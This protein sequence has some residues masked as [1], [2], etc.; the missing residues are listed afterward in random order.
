MTRR[1]LATVSAVAI[2]SLIGIAQS[3]TG[4]MVRADRSTSATD[5]DGAGAIKFMAMDG[6][7]H[8]VNPQA[9]VFWNAANS[10]SGDFTLKGTFTLVKP[11][12]HANFYGLVFGGSDLSGSE[13]TYLYFVIA[14][15][16]SW[17]VKQRTGNAATQNVVAKTPN[18][19]VKKPDASGQ[20]TNALEVRVSGEKVD[21]VINGTV[22]HSAPKVGPLAKT[23]GI[24]GIRV[25][26]QLEVMVKDF[27]LSK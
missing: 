24:A 7:F 15:N 8:T 4:W 2:A 17:L 11:S 5:P 21:F 9:G 12:G 10:A 25:N 27:A 14:Q 3:P 6:G 13:Q 26:H 16:G 1:I 23:D 19:A 20:S 18:G 22:V